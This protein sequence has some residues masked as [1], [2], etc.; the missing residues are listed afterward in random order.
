[1]LLLK[2]DVKKIGCGIENSL[3]HLNEREVRPDRL[4]IEVILRSANQFREIASFVV[5][6]FLG[7]RMY[8]LFLGEQHI[9]FTLG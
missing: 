1:L 2:A 7:A 6:N 5:P 4:R 9:E 8:L 3:L